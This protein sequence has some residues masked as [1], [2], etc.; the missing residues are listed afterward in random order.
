[1]DKQTVLKAVA[2]SLAVSCTVAI[3]LLLVGCGLMPKTEEEK[4]IERDAIQ[5]RQ[6]RL[7]QM[8]DTVLS[9]VLALF[10]VCLCVLCASCEVR[11]RMKAVVVVDPVT[12]AKVTTHVPDLGWSLMK[13]S[14]LAV[15]QWKSGKDSLTSVTVNGDE[16]LVPVAVSGDVTKVKLGQQALDAFLGTPGYSKGE[17]LVKGTKDPQ[18]IPVD[19]NAPKNMIVPAGSAV[20]PR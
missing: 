1:M 12:G 10:L 5:R 13:K 19:P 6:D 9:K 4:K 20:A 14:D 18:V 17:A 15:H 7:Q 8:T 3:L 11:P 16:T 2:R